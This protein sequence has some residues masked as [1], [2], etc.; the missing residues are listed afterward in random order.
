MRYWSLWRT[1]LTNR[2]LT[3]VPTIAIGLA[4]PDLAMMVQVLLSAI[5]T[6]Q[7]NE[8]PPRAF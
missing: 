3:P 6:M 4:V 1:A 8:A 5:E 2:M 7:G